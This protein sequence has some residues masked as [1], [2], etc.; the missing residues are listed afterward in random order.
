M[1]TL[2]GV[3]ALVDQGKKILVLTPEQDPTRLA[4]QMAVHKY[5]GVI[6]AKGTAAWQTQL[7]RAAVQDNVQVV[8]TDPELQQR[9]ESARRLEAIRRQ[10]MQ[11]VRGGMER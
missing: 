3:A 5:G 8:F 7:I 11:Q 2:A 10:A 1:Y 9:L 4:L 6:E